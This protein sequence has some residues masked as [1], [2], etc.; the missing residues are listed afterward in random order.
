QDVDR[1]PLQVAERRRTGSE[2]IDREANAQVPQR[3]Q[4]R[5]RLLDLLHEAALRQLQRE[6]G[7]LQLARLED[8]THPW[9]QVRL[10]Q[11]PRAEVDADSESGR[12][13][14][15]GARRAGWPA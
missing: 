4:L 3:S 9:D 7:W 1:E 12:G 2:V 14:A 11:L 6:R 10:E 13:R 15:V 5:D 8:L